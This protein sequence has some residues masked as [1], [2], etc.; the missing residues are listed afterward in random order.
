MPLRPPPMAG[1]FEPR[2]ITV[3]DTPLGARLLLHHAP[4]QARARGLVLY[5]HPFAE[6]MNKARRMAALQ[7]RALAAAGLAVAQL[8]LL[9]CG[10]SAGDFGDASWA[11]WVDDVVHAARWLQQRHPARDGE[12]AP[13]LWL[14]GLRAGT[15]LAVAAGARLAEAG[16]ACHYLFWQPAPLGK[17]LLQQFLRLRAAGELAAGQAKA[18]MEQLRAELAAGRAVEIAGYTLSPALCKGLE[19][20]ELQPPPAQSPGRL[21]WFELSAVE[22]PRLAPAGAATLA[23]WQQAGWQVQAQAVQGPPFWQ[24]TEIE[25]APALLDATARALLAPPSAQPAATEPAAA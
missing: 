4:A 18:A 13:P 22:N 16:S 12:S 5:V 2:F 19:Q 1:S 21:L 10:D 9:G 23:A 20:A 25:D 11:R 24:T 15:L 14:W 7:A 17:L 8:D 3:D 6:E